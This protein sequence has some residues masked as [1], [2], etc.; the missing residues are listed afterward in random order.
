MH[1][2]IDSFP[3]QS[4]IKYVHIKEIALSNKILTIYMRHIFKY[5]Y[6]PNIDI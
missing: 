4:F 2:N 1:N 6:N 5:A 3:I